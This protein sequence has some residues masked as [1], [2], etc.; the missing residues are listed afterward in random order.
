VK[1][2]VRVVHEGVGEQRRDVA[3]GQEAA[4]HEAELLADR[5]ALAA[6]SR[7]CVARVTSTRAT[8]TRGNG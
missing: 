7:R 4:W 3:A 6:S 2:P 5:V 1:K 8:V